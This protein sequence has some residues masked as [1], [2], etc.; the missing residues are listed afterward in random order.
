MGVHCAEGD[1]GTYV[2]A[3][4]LTSNEIDIKE[5]SNEIDDNDNNYHADDAYDDNDDYDYD[6]EI[7]FNYGI[8]DDYDDDNNDDFEIEYAGSKKKRKNEIVK[9]KLGDDD[10]NDDYDFEIDFNYGI[11]D[12]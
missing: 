6:F 8:D 11:D 1:P 12:I 4:L 7:A 3:K 9:T 5:I 10:F 2:S